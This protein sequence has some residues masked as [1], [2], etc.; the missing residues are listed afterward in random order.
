MHKLDWQ[1]KVVS[2]ICWR[3]QKAGRISLHLF[4][5]DFYIHMRL[6]IHNQI[7]TSSFDRLLC[8]LTVQILN[9][10]CLFIELKIINIDSYLEKYFL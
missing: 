8:L 4:P 3:G 10:Y 6:Y 1:G 9:L 7:H 2:L 5:L